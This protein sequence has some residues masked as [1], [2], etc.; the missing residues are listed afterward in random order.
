MTGISICS[1]PTAGLTLA[2]RRK[3]ISFTGTTAHGTFT[4]ITSGP[5]VEDLEQSQS[6]V[7]GDY[8]NDGHLDLFIVN[9]AQADASA[10]RNSLYRNNGD[11]TFTKITDSA[12]VK[13]GGNHA[14]RRLGRLR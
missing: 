11:G 3:R 4:K 6:G 5:V 2:A 12:I 9:Y 13:D 10:N 1:S 14:C 7:W 8:N